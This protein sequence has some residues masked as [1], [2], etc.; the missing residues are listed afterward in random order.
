MNVT[1]NLKQID[2]VGL[3]TTVVLLVI[4]M[5]IFFPRF[6]TMI[7]IEILAMG[8]IQE[9]IMSLGMTIII[10]SGGID[11]SIAGVLPFSA[12]IVGIFL[13]NNL[14]ISISI[15]LTLILAAIVGYINAAMINKLKVHPF[16]ATL[17]T[18]TTIKGIN[19]VI[20]EGKPVSG[21]PS[22]FYFLGQ[23]RIFG[24]P[25]PLILFVI[26]AVIFGYLL[27]N[28]KFFQQVYFIGNNSNAAR[29]SGIN[30]EKFI[31]VIYVIN[32]I[33]ASIAGIITASQYISANTGFGI[34]AELRVIT[35]VIIGGASLAGGKG[36]MGNTILGVLFLAIINNAFVQ[37]GAPTYW[38]EVVYGVMLL[39]AIFLEEYIRIKRG[40]KNISIKRW[41]DFLL[42][43]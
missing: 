32:A 13:N 26:L 1:K 37:T 12:I 21:F 6:L 15:I 33:L 22:E 4:L 7:N 27:K 28:H 14:G 11:L 25:F 5:T 3:L 42:S 30:V 19:L 29:Y 35:A 8:F 16:I 43:G 39:V 34:N 31:S 38:Q 24:I 10:I 36:K 17:A 18:L 40:G 2:N 20:T 23:G 9:A 41:R